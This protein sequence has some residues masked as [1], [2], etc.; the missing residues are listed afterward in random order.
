MCSA[1]FNEFE[2][3][4]IEKLLLVGRDDIKQF[5]PVRQ[6]L[7]NRKE[8]PKHTTFE[9]KTTEELTYSLKELVEYNMNTP[10]IYF[11]EDIA[12]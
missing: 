12:N 11:L 2:Y 9:A 4:F 6:Y 8:D 5:I 10:I 1:T 7:T 3:E